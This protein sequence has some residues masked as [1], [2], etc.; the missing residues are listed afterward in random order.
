MLRKWLSLKFGIK[1]RRLNLRG[2]RLPYT[3]LALFGLMD[4]VLLFAPHFGGRA[5]LPIG[6]TM[7]L[8]MEFVMIS[9]FVAESLLQSER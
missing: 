7:V 5:M 8:A 6:W 1:T 3:L 2:I 4:A 9:A